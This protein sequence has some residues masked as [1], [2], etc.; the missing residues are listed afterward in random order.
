VKFY[1]YFGDHGKAHC[2]VI[3]NDC[4]ATILIETGTSFEVSRFSKKDV[5]ELEELVKKNAQKLVKAW[6]EYNE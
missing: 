3:K 1:I 6:E 5:N 4:E 2:H